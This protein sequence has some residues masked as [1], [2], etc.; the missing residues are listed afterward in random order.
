MDELTD[1]LVSCM[2]KSQDDQDL[3]DQVIRQLRDENER[4]KYELQLL[5]NTYDLDNSATEE[6]NAVLRDR[7]NHLL[8]AKADLEKEVAKLRYAAPPIMTTSPP[9]GEM[10]Q[11]K[12]SMNR[13]MNE[14][15][16]SSWQIYLPRY[17][18]MPLL[19]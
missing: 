5:R 15:E 10:L 16:Q 8:T 1:S 4:L 6:M 17:D 19:S 9:S 18:C 3:D 7:I 2:T 14:N 13:I 11:N 12:I